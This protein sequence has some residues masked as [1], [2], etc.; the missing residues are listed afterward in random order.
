MDCTSCSETCAWCVTPFGDGHCFDF[1]VGIE[2]LNQT[3]T[4]MIDAHPLY[5]GLLADSMTSNGQCKYTSKLP[6]LAIP[7]IFLT[8][9]LCL[10]VR[11]S[12]GWS[13]AGQPPRRSL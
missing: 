8:D 5:C 10:Q 2:V 11:I 6:V 12:C 13:E 7:R 4:S 1:D 3:N 9:C